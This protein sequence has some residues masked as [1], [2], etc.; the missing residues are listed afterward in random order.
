MNTLI[1]VLMFAAV[2][3]AVVKPL[4]EG[5]P[6]GQVRAIIYEDLQCSDCAVFREMMDKRI[7]P[8]YGDRVAFE[9]PPAALGTS[10][11]VAVDLKWMEADVL[12]G[13]ARFEDA[14][15]PFRAKR[16]VPR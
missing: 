10:G 6:S 7:L 9:I 5:N 1:P 13:T 12:E 3:S 8:K 15:R 2:S 14:P 16:D 4:V 11:K